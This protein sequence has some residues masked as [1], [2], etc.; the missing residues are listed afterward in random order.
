M[1]C[2]VIYALWGQSMGCR[3][4]VDHELLG[5]VPKENGKWSWKSQKNSWNMKIGQRSR[6]FVFSH[7]ILPILSPELLQIFLSPIRN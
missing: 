6:N 3:I 4:R 1:V 5:R 7:D 2:G